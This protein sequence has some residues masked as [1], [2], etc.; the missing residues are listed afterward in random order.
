MISIAGTF[1]LSVCLLWVLLQILST[2][3]LYY[4]CKKIYRTTYEQGESPT[5]MVPHTDLKQLKISSAVK[6]LLSRRMAAQAKRWMAD[7]ISTKKNG[8][9][10]TASS[11]P[12]DLY[13]IMIRLIQIWKAYLVVAYPVPARKSRGR[14]IR[15]TD[16]LY[17]DKKTQRKYD[18]AINL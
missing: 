17:I 3:R 18:Q 15:K 12:L 13:L 9:D 14:N 4:N 8:K 16:L 11:A 6:F 2:G 7:R 10:L 5:T 1:S